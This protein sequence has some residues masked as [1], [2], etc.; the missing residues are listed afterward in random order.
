MQIFIGTNYID[1]DH[2]HGYFQVKKSSSLREERKTGNYWNNH[3]HHHYCFVLF[4]V[5]AKKYRESN[6]DQT[7]KQTNGNEIPK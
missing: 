5:K 4:S 1:Q 7:N 3:H 2:H 6:V